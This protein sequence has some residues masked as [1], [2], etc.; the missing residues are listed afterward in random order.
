MDGNAWRRGGAWGGGVKSEKR[1]AWRDSPFKR[2]QVFY[3]WSHRTNTSQISNTPRVGIRVES[4][5]S[6]RTQALPQWPR[7]PGVGF[8]GVGRQRGDTID[9]KAQPT[10]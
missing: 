2:L 7:P 10:L 8:P 5:S 3:T 1:H 4:D 9:E 6:G